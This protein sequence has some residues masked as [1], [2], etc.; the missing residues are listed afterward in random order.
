MYRAIAWFSAVIGVVSYLVA[1]VLL[2]GH[3][4][5]QSVG[6]AMI[7]LIPSLVIGIV[8]HLVGILAYKMAPAGEL[9]VRRLYL[10][11]LVL[12]VLGI[13]ALVYSYNS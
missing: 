4:T 6:M 7:L 9:R 12:F 10:T 13:V 8:N 1:V 3:F 11:Q 2:Y 5:N